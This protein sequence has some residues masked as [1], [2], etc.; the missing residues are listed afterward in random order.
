MSTEAPRSKVSTASREVKRHAF[1]LKLRP[2]TERAYDKLHQ[3]VPPDL[4]ALLKRAGISGYSI[5]RRDQLLF[6]TLTVVD[7]ER[8]WQTIEIDPAYKAWQKVMEP[9]FDT[10]SDLRPGER[11]PMM[12]EVFYLP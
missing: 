11:F 3:S 2:G 4:I 9:F 5:F 1:L 6:L 7:F 8:A 10:L 12:D